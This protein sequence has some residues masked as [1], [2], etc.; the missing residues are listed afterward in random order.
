MKQVLSIKRFMNIVKYIKEILIVNKES[1]HTIG[2]E[3]LYNTAN[4][5][6]RL[7]HTHK[8]EIK[9]AVNWGDLH[10]VDTKISINRGGEVEYIVEIEEAAPYSNDLIAFVLDYLKDHGCENIPIR[11]T[12]EW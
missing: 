2:L 10:C 1:V 8:Q 6:V 3:N 7:A 11:V 12:T 4:D 5:A 9:D